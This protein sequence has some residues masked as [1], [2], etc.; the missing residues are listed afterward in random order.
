ML[1]KNYQTDVHSTRHFNL[2]TPLSHES[3][4]LAVEKK[5]ACNGYG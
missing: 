4:D 3:K 2:V 1:T 5:T